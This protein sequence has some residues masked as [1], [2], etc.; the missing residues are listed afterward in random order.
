MSEG[1][2]IPDQLAD[3]QMEENLRGVLQ[4][5]YETAAP[6]PAYRARVVAELTARRTIYTKNIVW[7]SAIAAIMIIALVLYGMGPLQ[8]IATVSNVNQPRLPAGMPSWLV[9]E[10]YHGAEIERVTLQD[11]ASFEMYMV[12][13]AEKVGALQVVAITDAQVTLQDNNDASVV[14]DS[15][16]DTYLRDYKSR[17]IVFLTAQLRAGVLAAADLER[18]ARLAK[19]EG[20]GALQALLDISRQSTH[21]LHDQVCRQLGGDAAQWEQLQLLVCL[22]TQGSQTSRLQ[23]IRALRDY[24]MP[25]TL[26]YFR[27]ALQQTQDPLLPVVVEEA[28]KLRDPQLRDQLAGLANQPALSQEL[29][30]KITFLLTEKAIIR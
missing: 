15:T 4:H 17:Q 23:A 1:H 6:D 8:H 22:A 12:G 28:V 9:M 3:K 27:T 10:R 16:T 30:N 26:Q 13:I 5:H 7:L 20:G 14:L 21:A 24:P 29:R 2:D 19:Q 25:L 18:F 11:V